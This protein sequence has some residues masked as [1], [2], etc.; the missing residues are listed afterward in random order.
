MERKNISGGHKGGTDRTA[1]VT[2][3]P[4]GWK[5]GKYSFPEHALSTGCQPCT[6]AGASENQAAQALPSQSFQSSCKGGGCN[7]YKPVEC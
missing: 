7:K 3:D 4:A 1:A 5:L 2:T 6:S